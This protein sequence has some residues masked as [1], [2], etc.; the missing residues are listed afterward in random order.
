M[1]QVFILNQQV[2]V[3]VQQHVVYEHGHKRVDGSDRVGGLLLLDV[4]RVGTVNC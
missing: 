1:N 4:V 3:H 2:L